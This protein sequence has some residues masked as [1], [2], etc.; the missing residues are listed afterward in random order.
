MTDAY[1][2]TKDNGIV[3]WED[4]YKSYQKKKKK[5]KKPKSSKT[6]FYNVGANEEANMS[7]EALKA[8]LA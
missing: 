5:C 3:N 2:W 8:R 1:L 6:R 4:Y 7:N